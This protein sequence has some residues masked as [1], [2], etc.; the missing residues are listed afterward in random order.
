MK[1]RLLFF[2]ACT[3]FITS[4][5]YAEVYFGG[6]SSF[7]FTS[8]EEKPVLPELFLDGGFS[9]FHPFNKQ[10]SLFF[11]GGGRFSYFP[12]DSQISGK[13]SLTGDVSFRSGD[14][15]T[16][17][18]LGS[19]VEH[20]DWLQNPYWY[21]HAEWYLSLDLDS[22][23]LFAAPQGI[24]EIE[25]TNHTAGIEGRIGSSFDLAT[26][27]LTPEFNAGI[28]FL[29][30]NHTAGFYGPLLDLSWYPGAPLT[31]SN[32]LG[33]KRNDST[34]TEELT[35]GSTLETDDYTTV[36]IKPKASFFL[37]K[38]LTMEIL[39]PVD[40][41]IHDHGYIDDTQVMEDRQ[42]TFYFSP[43]INVTVDTASP[44]SFL[45]SGGLELIHSNSSYVN[46]VSGTVTVSADISF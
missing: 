40:L 21:Q 11:D 25:D 17:L 3:L 7:S 37:S 39:T 18:Q 34:E 29:P 16:K 30:D 14:F 23:S 38:F 5:L 27:I 6:G 22:V 8:S 28:H 26:V 33:V 35:G 12:V 32:S 10:W 9:L 42:I 45:V 1:H 24:W 20:A 43:E 4:A 46:D 36:F 44:V 13:A 31:L 41:T 2:F 19:Y 15:F